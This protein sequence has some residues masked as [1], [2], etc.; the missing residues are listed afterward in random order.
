VTA[1]GGLDV[2][3]LIEAPPGHTLTRLACAILPDVPAMAA[4]E[5]RWD[6]ILRAARRA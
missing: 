4:D 1:L 3:L 6:V 5:T 2:A